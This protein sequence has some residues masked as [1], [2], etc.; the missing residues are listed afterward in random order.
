MNDIWRKASD[1]TPVPYRP[2]CVHIRT[3]EYTNEIGGKDIYKENIEHN[4]HH[5]PLT[6]LCADDMGFLEI[7]W[8]AVEEWCY[9]EDLTKILLEDLKKDERG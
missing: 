8:N 2:L 4:M 5:I 6:G 1:F 9:E 7:D 3:H